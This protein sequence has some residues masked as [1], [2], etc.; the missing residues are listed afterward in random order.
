LK[1]YDIS[2]RLINTL[3]QQNLKP[4][5]YDVSFDASGYSSGV[6]FYTLTSG[7]YSETKKMLFIK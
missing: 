2:G 3:V 1:V 4:G 6:Y 5:N 7:T